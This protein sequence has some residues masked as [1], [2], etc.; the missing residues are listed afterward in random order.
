MGFTV[1]NFVSDMLK[2]LASITRGF[3]SLGEGVLDFAYV[4][5]VGLPFVVLGYRQTGKTT[6]LAYM[7][8]NLQLLDTDAWQPEP[9]TAGGEAV[10]VFTTRLEGEGFRLRPRRDVGGE[11]AMWETDWVDLFQQAKP[12]GLIFLIDHTRPYQHKD[13]LNFAMNLVEDEAAAGRKIKALLLIVNKMDLWK[14]EKSLDDVLEDFRNE[15]R[16]MRSQAERLGYRLIIQPASV[17][18]GEGVEEGLHEFFNAVRPK[19]R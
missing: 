12:R 2:G 10:P 5:V 3:A 1:P 19:A 15:T 4:R 14:E 9:T 7:R 13:A 17:L 16:R 6:L 8:R 18:S 11:Y